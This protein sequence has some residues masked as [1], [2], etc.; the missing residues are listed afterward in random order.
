MRVLTLS[1]AL[2][3]CLVTSPSLRAQDA[4]ANPNVLR[5]QID[6]L[7]QQLKRIE[8]SESSRRKVSEIDPGQSAP[9]EPAK[10][11]ILRAYDLH[12]LFADISQYPAKHPSDIDA[13]EVLQ[14]SES[15][16][17]DELLATPGGMGGGMGGMGG[18]MGGSG[19]GFMQ[20]GAGATVTATGSQASVYDLIAAIQ[21]TTS[22]PWQEVHGDGGTI[23]RIGT[24]LLIRASQENH[25][26][27]ERLL[28][29]LRS[30]WGSLKLVSVECDWL[31]LTSDELQSPAFRV[32]G[33]AIRVVD[34]GMLQSIRDAQ[35]QEQ[36]PLGRFALI[37]CYN[38][39]TVHLQSLRQVPAVTSVTPVLGSESVGY[40]PQVRALD[41]GL[42]AQIR[43]T[44]SR[45]GEYVALDLHSRLNDVDLEPQ[46][47]YEAS[48]TRLDRPQLKTHRMSTTIRVPVGAT[49][50]VGG[51]SGSRPQEGQ[52]A[53][54]R[55]FTLCLF[56]R[57][58][59]ET[60]KE[61]PAETEGKPGDDFS[62]R[63]GVPDAPE[64]DS[65][66]GR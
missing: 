22:G 54:D 23:S 49:T 11:N 50:L 60:V 25:E 55:E 39:Q 5:Q 12:D 42:I 33:K 63:K 46:F 15:I 32:P 53:P 41:E 44:V 2:G 45:S 17:G 35:G 28:D 14:F 18:G 19:G 31:W 66:L 61:A 38:G 21:E 64:K 10:V 20:V 36:R 4:A 24:T 40:S 16:S 3:L 58:S 56:V 65:G 48:G 13:R 37:S 30:S 43:P 52:D 9:R 57:A 59:V 34:D 29:V 47:A 6:A 7:Q 51:I 8:R 27:I 1:A 62:P 26:Q